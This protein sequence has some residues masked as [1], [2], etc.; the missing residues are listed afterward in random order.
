MQ[1]QQGRVK[2]PL[3]A[4]ALAV[5][6]EQNCPR[7]KARL[8]PLT[9]NRGERGTRAAQ[10]LRAAP[11][12]QRRRAFRW[13]CCPCR[14]CCSATPALVASRESPTSA[15]PHCAAAAA[16]AAGLGTAGWPVGSGQERG[17]PSFSP[18][19]RYASLPGA[20]NAP[21]ASSTC[22][23]PSCFFAAAVRSSSRWAAELGT[24]CSSPVPFS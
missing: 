24:C 11:L 15:T 13:C 20:R 17:A 6:P 1:R 8:S 16:A 19:I 12:R 9:L 4:A 23:S 5:C 7:F 14:Y 2:W 3:P 21:R 18:D 22:S 10:G